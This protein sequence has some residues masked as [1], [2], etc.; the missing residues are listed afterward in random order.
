MKDFLFVLFFWDFFGPVTKVEN[1]NV[2]TGKNIEVE[3]A[4]ERGR[5]LM[6]TAMFWGTSSKI[7]LDN[8]IDSH[9]CGEQRRHK[10]AVLTIIFSTLVPSPIF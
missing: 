8:K 7:L 5:I 9:R 1:I 3:T 4:F 2:D 6:L 10:K